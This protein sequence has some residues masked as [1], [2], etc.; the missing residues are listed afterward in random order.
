MPSDTPM[1]RQYAALKKQYPDCILFFRMGDFFEMFYEDAEVASRVLE[2][3]L[4]ARHKDSADPVPMAG[5]P[6]H[7]VQGYLA[8]MVQAGYRVAVCEQVEEAAKA[9][10]LVRREVVRVVTPGTLTDEGALA[11]KENQ[12]VGSIYPAPD[13]AGLA[14][15]DLSTGEFNATELR[16]ERWSSVL[17][18]ECFRVAP[19]EV[20]VPEGSLETVSELAF[21]EG[22]EEWRPSLH[23]YDEWAY[24]LEYAT[25]SLLDQLGA[26]SLDGFGLSDA[27]LAVRAAGSLVHYLRQTQMSA[28]EHI[29]S[30]SFSPLGATMLLDRLTVRNLELLE[31]AEG[32][33]PLSLLGI[34][35]QTVTPMGGRLLKQWVLQPRIELEPIERRLEAVETFANDHRRRE[36]FRDTLAKVGDIER[37]VGRVVLGTATARDMVALKSSCRQLPGLAEALEGATAT[38]LE[39]I[40]GAWDDCEDVASII[41]DAI[42]E[43]PPLALTEGGIIRNG[44]H[45][46]LDELRGIGREGKGSIAGLEAEER[47]RT[48]IP[49]LKVGYNKVFGYYLEVTKKHHDRVPEHYI[50][51][52]TLVGAERYITPEL[53]EYEARVLGAEERAKALEYEVFLQTREALK[54]ETVRLQQAARRVALLD[55]F[56]AL[57]E[58]AVKYDY[59]RPTLTDGDTITISDGRHPVLEQLSLGERFVPNDT[60]LDRG[61]NSILIITGPNMAGKSTYLRQT[62]II[63][64]LAQIGS[65][66][67]ARGATIG[68]VDRIFTRIGAQDYLTR[69]Q[70]TF[71]VEMNETA[72]ILNNATPRSLIILDEIGRGTSTFDGLSIA[73]AVVEY[74]HNQPQL[75]ARTLFATH[76]HELTE[77]SLLLP[78]VKNYNIAVREW[79]DQIVFLRKIVPG[80]TDKSYGI[81]VARLAGLPRS[82]LERAKEVLSTLESKEFDADGR[83]ILA[84]PGPPSHPGATQLTLLK[85]ADAKLAEALK[86]ID[87]ETISPMEALNI[88]AG[89]RRL[90]SESEEG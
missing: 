30:I 58:A 40:R 24:G 19:K 82:V 62:A 68:L 85:N 43:D 83:P 17:Q 50:R 74:L 88:L 7:S 53:K 60:L 77:L 25:K 21:L 59:V 78:G 65:F 4:T 16:G 64:L 10:G 13:G 27:P 86:G 69:G 76:Y 47:E 44:F 71:M 81:Q 41:E 54:A 12:Y 45:P 2:I 49:S 38:L 6:H 1:M 31:S 9:K 90:L 80:G 20:L 55:V 26:H 15:L 36:A 34:L 23:P 8:K 29:N 51:K 61:E 79:A 52:Q 35:D 57:A 75:K 5:V 70:S 89:L 22:E 67:P 37:V 14:M 32:A 42:E 87:P 73:W 33:R 48:G 3:T 63:V 84:S 11:P 18:D 46:E 56:G 66:V 28:L 39:E 72:N